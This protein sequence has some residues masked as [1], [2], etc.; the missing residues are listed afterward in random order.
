MGFSDKVSGL[1]EEGKDKVEEFRQENRESSVDEDMNYDSQIEDFDNE[2]PQTTSLDSEE[3][4]VPG[5][6]YE[7]AEEENRF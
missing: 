4:E 2:A 7:A 5:A 3:T 1:F 6:T